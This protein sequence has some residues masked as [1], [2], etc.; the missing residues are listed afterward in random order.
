M[1]SGVSGGGQVGQSP[2]QPDPLGA[3]EGGQAGAQGG[4]V[5]AQLVGGLGLAP[6]PG[7]RLA[8]QL[9]GYEAARGLALDVGLDAGRLAAAVA[10]LDV[11]ELVGQGAALLDLEQ[12]AGQPDAV[13]VSG[14]QDKRR[15]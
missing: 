11:D 2:A 8:E 15:Q 1:N 5:D 3:G 4:D 12:A 14:P 7:Q 13:P 9:Q 6:G 10:A